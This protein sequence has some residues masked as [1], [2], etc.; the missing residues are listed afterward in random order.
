MD[1]DKFTVSG[2]KRFYVVTS[3]V[4]LIGMGIVCAW[5]LTQTTSVPSSAEVV[6]SPRAA[7][8]NPCDY[9]LPS[10]RELEADE[11]VTAAECFVIQNGYTDLPPVADKT[12]L[13]PE[14]LFPGTDDEGMKMRHD[15]LERKAY[16]YEHDNE[17]YG[18][19][20]V[21]M[22][23]YKP[24]PEV[25]KFYGDRLSHIGRSV[26]MDFTGKRIWIQHSDYSLG[27][28]DARV[29]PSSPNP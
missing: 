4:A 5:A 15:S 17:L 3:L 10:Y 20:W 24:N 14:N 28:P 1:S 21:V 12:K 13:T 16:S 9:P 23:R 2:N 8:D 11:A 6:V 19:S 25:V 27:K 22:F 26:I 18:G 29:I 7:S